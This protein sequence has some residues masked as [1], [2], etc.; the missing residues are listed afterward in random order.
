[1][2]PVQLVGQRSTERSSRLQ[3]SECC[4]CSQLN[5]EEQRGPVD[6][7]RVNVACAASW[8]EMCRVV[9]WT[10]GG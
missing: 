4:L 5:G 9:W 3:A 6:C 2:L 8:P 10:A 1:M 7:R